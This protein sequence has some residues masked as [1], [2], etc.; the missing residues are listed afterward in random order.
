VTRETLAENFGGP[1]GDGLAVVGS[2]EGMGGV[3]GGTGAAGGGETDAEVDG[4]TSA[5]VDAP[6]AVPD[7]QPTATARV[8]P[9]R[10]AKREVFI[11]CHPPYLTN[12]INR[13]CI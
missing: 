6:Q 3:G 2:G 12:T 8:V 1:V 4:G 9:I 7:R 11:C 5:E 10:I 13:Q